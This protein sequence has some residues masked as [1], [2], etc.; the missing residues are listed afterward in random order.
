MGWP[1][2]VVPL[3][4]T[5][6]P[7]P[8]SNPMP[9]VPQLGVGLPVYLP[10]SVLA[11]RQCYAYAGL[12]LAVRVSVHQ[13]SWSGRYCFLGWSHLLTTSGF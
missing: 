7:F 2:S 10:S 12:V 11:L 8:H 6:F 9:M 13:P 1:W 4:K 3:E 5:D